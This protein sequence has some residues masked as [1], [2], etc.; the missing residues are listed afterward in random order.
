MN[1]FLKTAAKNPF[2]IILII[3][4]N[5]KVLILKR[6]GIKTIVYNMHHDYFFC[7]FES[8]YRLLSENP[9][10]RLFIAYKYD[11]RLKSYLDSL[12]L[13]AKL[14]DNRISPFINFDMFITAE[15]TGPDFPFK[16]LSTKKLEIYHGTGTYNLYG[17]LPVLK[18][19][20]IHFA[21]GKQYQP[22]FFK[23]SGL[24]NHSR[25]YEIGY[26]KTDALI[27]NEYKNQSLIDRY[28]LSGK[29][30]VLYAPHWNEFSS[31]HSIGKEM[32][33][34]LS[35]LDIFIIIK[36]HNYIFTKFPEAKWKERLEEWSEEFINVRIMN[37]PDTQSFY[38]ISDSII[39]DVGTTAG[40]EYSLIK[41]PLFIYKDIRWF[42]GKE[43]VQPETD[44]LD[45][46][47]QFTS[48]DEIYNF[49]ERLYF[50]RDNG[51]SELLAKQKKLQQRLI[52][53]YI[54]NPGSA[55]RAGYE[56]ILK[57]LGLLKNGSN[58]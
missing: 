44:I 23:A 42:E 45:A 12:N 25:V 19:F 50:K 14:I 26:P 22:D 43:G 57:E 11:N 3:I 6:K 41:K 29:P 56:A 48:A 1:R 38:N 47:I 2:L 18:R 33:R 13:T 15:I 4:W 54:F 9:N 46:S 51:I 7:T 32:I 34:K 5:I 20:D 30:V 40:L 28:R 27:N 53:N 35:G 55:S 10:I 39:T 8:L 37:E 52:D 24:I 31:I 16:W 17:E 49:T 21:I 58:E 36:V